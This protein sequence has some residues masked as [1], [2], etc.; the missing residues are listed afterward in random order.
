M[1]AERFELDIVAVVQP[2]GQGEYKLTICTRTGVPDYTPALPEPTIFSTKSVDRDFF[3]H[4][5]NFCVFSLAS[6]SPSWFYTVVNAERATY[7]APSFAPKIAR[8]RNVLL[9][10]IVD[11]AIK[12]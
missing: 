4:K 2:A 1:S 9:Q 7:K 8:T 12:K 6:H 10:N 11:S 5:R 3:F